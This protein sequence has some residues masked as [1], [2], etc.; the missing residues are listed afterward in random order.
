MPVLTVR[1][2]DRTGTLA[3]IG[4]LAEAASNL[5]DLFPNDGQTILAVINGSAGAV[6]VSVSFGANAAVDGSTPAARVLTVAAG[7][8]K[9]FGFWKPFDWNN[10]ESRVQ[11]AYD[12]VTDIKVLALK[13]DG[14]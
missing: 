9:L 1:V 10:S 5:G 14:V 12:T 13:P 4:D 7:K 3:A 6:N 8:T 11:L 2:L